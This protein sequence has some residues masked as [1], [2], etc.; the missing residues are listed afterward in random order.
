D[1]LVRAASPLETLDTNVPLP[2]D[3]G[4]ATG[5]AVLD[6]ATIHLHDYAA[7]PESEYPLGRQI[8]RRGGYHTTAATPVGHGET[9]IGALAIVRMAVRPFTARELQL[10][11]TFAA[12]AA[13]AIQNA[14]LFQELQERTRELAQLVER[15]TALFEVSQAVSST[16]DLGQVLKT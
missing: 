8:Q 11:E 4:W 7:V 14:R 9:V 10:L 16:L 2:L 15:L 3:R 5:R 13:I 6:R 12:Q 1:T